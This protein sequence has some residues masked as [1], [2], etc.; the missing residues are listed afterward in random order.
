MAVRFVEPGGAVALGLLQRCAS[1]PAR[2]RGQG[3]GACSGNVSGG[4]R[5]GGG[6]GELELVDDRRA[7]GA[8]ACR[9]NGSREVTPRHGARAWLAGAGGGTCGM[10]RAG[11]SSISS[12]VFPRGGEETPGPPDAS[13]EPLASASS[14]VGLVGGSPRRERSPHAE[15]AG[16][17]AS[18]RSRSEGGVAGGQARGRSGRA[19]GLRAPSRQAPR[20]ANGGCESR[21]RAH[22]RRAGQCQYMSREPGRGRMC[23]GGRP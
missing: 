9:G 16:R 7:R 19:R 11:A 4:R 22:A 12:R 1:A 13:I 17:R 18:S 15:V 3:A 8:G 10:T 6:L 2:G 21:Q 14:L 5:N 20:P 23:A